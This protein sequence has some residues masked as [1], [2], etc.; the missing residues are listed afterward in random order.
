MQFDYMFE[1]LKEKKK[2]TK[3]SISSKI[4]LEK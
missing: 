1:V 4:I 2:S 3:N